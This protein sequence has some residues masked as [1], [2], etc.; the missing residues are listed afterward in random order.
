MKRKTFLV[1][2][3]GLT[4]AGVG[5]LAAGCGTAAS[6]Y[7]F[8]EYKRNPGN[9][10]LYQAEKALLDGKF[11]EEIWKNAKWHAMTSCQYNRENG[12]EQLGFSDCNY[13]ATVVTDAKG[14]YVGMKSDDPSLYV[15]RSWN[16]P[17]VVSNQV[18]STAFGK[19]GFSIYLSDK[20]VQNSGYE[21]GF[22][23][24]GDIEAI[25]REP[26]RRIRIGNYDL[27]SGIDLRGAK[28]NDKN[29]DGYAIEIFMPW[30]ALPYTE[31]EPDTVSATFA[32]HRYDD[33]NLN[34]TQSQPLC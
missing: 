19:T 34:S 13:E 29:T 4:L 10:E 33:F 3:I 28:L 21:I 26:G 9:A 2:V 8:D 11:D 6:S 25:R 17:Y 23:V 18:P 20:K 27:H 5:T 16:D 15:G 14:V 22:S 31:G 12:N 7:K 30:S 1:T 32:S 24:D